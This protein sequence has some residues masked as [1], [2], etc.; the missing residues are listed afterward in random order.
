MKIEMNNSGGG[1][2]LRNAVKKFARRAGTARSR[3]GASLAATLLGV[4]QDMV[5]DERSLEDVIGAVADSAGVDASAISAMLDAESSECPT[6]ETLLAVA[7][8]LDVSVDTLK[9]AAEADGC[10]YAAVDAEEGEGEGEGDGGGGEPVA[11]QRGPAARNAAATNVALFAQF[12]Q[13]ESAR[14]TAIR[15]MFK[16]F[17][18]HGGAEP[19][20]HQCLDDMD[21]SATTANTRL[22]AFLGEQSARG[23]STTGGN[24]R[25]TQDGATRTANGLV[26]SL[27]A[28]AGIVPF[29]P[30]NEFNGMR[31]ANIARHCLQQQAVSSIPNSDDAVIRMALSRSGFWLAGADGGGHTSADFGHILANVAQKAMLKGWEAA[32]ETFQEW[33]SVGETSDFKSFK[34]AGSGEFSDLLQIDE[35]GE[36]EYGTMSDYG[37]LA[38]LLTFGR[39]FLI[40]RQAL[41]NDDLGAFTKLPAKMGGAARRK[42]GDLA[43]NILFANAQLG[44]GVALFHASHN[45]ELTNAPPSVAAIAAMRTAMRT[46]RDPDNHVSALNIDLAKIITGVNQEDTFAVLRDAQY[47]PAA[48]VLNMPNSQRGRFDVV[49]DPRVDS[50]ANPYY[51]YGAGNPDRFDTVEMTYL[52][53]VQTPF[54]DQKDT[55]TVDGA[56]FKVRIDAVASALDYRALTRN[57]YDGTP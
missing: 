14:K 16:P 7:T 31:L 8:A 27:A 24:M 48:T 1:F 10:A 42:L 33:T 50:S 6:A 45:N 52:N 5:S 49:S 4:L 39:L 11:R 57:P 28:R 54:L 2:V 23:G 41:I 38:A 55:W 36:Y 46:Q 20:L 12:R 43:Y 56:S 13:S 44:D 25:M 51:W 30:R 47:D 21:V 40:S 29:D 19:L 18:A 53:G 9:Q 15:A 26:L 3:N 32:E 37:T 22:L 17:L 34:R 35:D